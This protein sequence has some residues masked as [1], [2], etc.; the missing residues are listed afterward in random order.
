MQPESGNGQD[1]KGGITESCRN[2]AAL[3][4][5]ADD[6]IWVVGLDFGI[7]SMN[8]AAQRNMKSSMGLEAPLGARPVDLVSPAEAATWNKFYERTL[9]EGTL[10]VEH[11]TPEGVELETTFNRIV[12]DGRIVGI[13]AFGKEIGQRKAT[14]RAL[15]EAEKKYHSIFDGALEGMFQTTWEGELLTANRA[16]IRMLGYESME[17]AIGTI[18]NLGHDLW[19]DSAARQEYLEEVDKR[20][21]VRG[22]ECRFRRKDGVPIWVSFSARKVEGDSQRPGYLEGFLEDITARKQAE[23]QLTTAQIALRVSEERYR[24]TF[25]MSLDAININRLSDGLYIECNAAFL[26]AT[27]YA[28][29]EVIGRTSLELNIWADAGDRQAMAARVSRGSACRNVE[30]QFT[31]KNGEVFWGLISASLIELDGTACILS[32][33][34]DISEAK[35]AAEEIRSLAFY[36]PLTH[37]PNRRLLLERLRV[38]TSL[39]GGSERLWAILFVDLDDFK[40]VND[41]A[42]HYTGDLLLQAVASRMSGCVRESDTVAR[43]GG[44][45]FVVMLESL[46]GTAHEA[47]T[48]ARGIAEKILTALA[49]PYQLAGYECRCTASIGIALFGSNRESTSE[50]LKQADIAMYQAKAAG[51]NTVRFFAPEL[52]TAVNAKASLE[53]EL[54]QGLKERQ[55][56][57]WYQPQIH[58]DWVVGAEA[59]I[60]WNHPCRGHLMPDTFIPLAE[61]TGLIVSLGNWVLDSACAQLAQWAHEKQTEHLSLSVNISVRQLRQPDFVEQVLGALSAPAPIPACCSWRSPKACWR[62]TSTRSSRG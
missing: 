11:R 8:R 56:A 21:L 29:D 55:F 26:K 3:I 48:R 14:E 41:T 13:S 50:I 10:R 46:E 25:Q 1:G 32:V 36:D 15:V 44:D 9:A 38:A 61:E 53:N 28:R 18:K 24:T 17:D 2:L 20:G 19:I 6:P 12:V 7:L 37:L 52:Q 39:G 60:R 45:E 57:L 58:E 40:T 4:E 54:R 51:R 49:E 47:A 43:L 5:G 30:V 34:R 33:T 23:E 27:G 59:L 31:K 35:A 42:G 62:I 22:L 16:A